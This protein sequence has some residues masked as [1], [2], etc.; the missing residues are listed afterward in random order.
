MC[1][2]RSEQGWVSFQFSD[3]VGRRLSGARDRSGQQRQPGL[4]NGL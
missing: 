1:E 4:P 3:I 2:R